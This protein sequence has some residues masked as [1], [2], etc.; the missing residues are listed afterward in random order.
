MSMKRGEY[1]LK[2]K[3]V[4]VGYVEARMRKQNTVLAIA[5]TLFHDREVESVCVFDGRGT[6]RLF[7]KK[8]LATGKCV[9]RERH[10]RMRPLSSLKN[11]PLTA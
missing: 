10:K 11:P 8:D 4:R 5:G 9:M 2:V 1:G 6:P 3:I 7:L